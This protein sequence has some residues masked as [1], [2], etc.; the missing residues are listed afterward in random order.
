MSR[1]PLLFQV[2]DSERLILNENPLVLIPSYPTLEPDLFTNYLIET[3]S[4]MN[5][6]IAF[7]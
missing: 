2:V 4:Y 1:K 6:V 3:L 5:H 7:G